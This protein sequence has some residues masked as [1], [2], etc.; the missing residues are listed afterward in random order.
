[1]PLSPEESSLRVGIDPSL[2]S[3]TGSVPEAVGCIGLLILWRYVE[4]MSREMR[5]KWDVY[6]SLRASGRGPKTLFWR[7]LWHK[8][9]GLYSGNDML[10]CDPMALVRHPWTLKQVEFASALASIQDGSV[11][12]QPDERDHIAANMAS[13]GTILGG[14]AALMMVTPLTAPAAPVVGAAAGAIG[15]TGEA[16]NFGRRVVDDAQTS[17]IKSQMKQYQAIYKREEMYRAREVGS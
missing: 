3:Q 15:G 17:R 8:K 9:N 7:E 11:P 2:I 1:M 10:D 6:V 5:I 12:S 13:A 16:I 14:A 4:I